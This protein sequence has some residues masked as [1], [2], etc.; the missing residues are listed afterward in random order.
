MKVSQHPHLEL[1]ATFETAIRFGHKSFFITASIVGLLWRLQKVEISISS[2]G[3][4]CACWGANLLA[5]QKCRSRSVSCRIRMDLGM[6][7]TFL[8]VRHQERTARRRTTMFTCIDDSS[9]NPIETH[10][11]CSIKFSQPPTEDQLL[12][13]KEQMRWA[14]Q[15]IACQAQTPFWQRGHGIPS[16]SVSDKWD[17]F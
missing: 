2:S 16:V 17:F 13:D 3:R 11:L 6:F 5:S 1:L 8:V 14:S 10:W 9:A 4:R 15:Q 12:M 7:R